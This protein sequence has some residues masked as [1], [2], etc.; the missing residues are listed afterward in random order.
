MK[1]TPLNRGSSQLKRSPLKSNTPLARSKKPIK[2]RSAKTAKKYREERVP[3][4]KKILAERPWCEACPKW[5]EFD[6]LTFFRRRES[7]DCHEIRS[8]GRTG[9]VRSD[10]W[11]DPENILAVC[12][13]CHDRIGRDVEDAEK[14][15][16]L[17]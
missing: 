3:L 7:V 14:L 6:G 1:R 16:L 11:L 9:G 8:R 12:R 2:N 15:G 4:V 17:A 10:E 13:V 5:A